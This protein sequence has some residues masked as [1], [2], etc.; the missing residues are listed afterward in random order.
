MS[1]SR[2]RKF[3]DLLDS[4]GGIKAEALG[5]AAST[6]TDIS[7][8]D[9]LST[10]YFD[11]PSGG[12]AQR[13]SSPNI[14]YM[15]YNTN[16]DCI[17]QYT[18]TGWKGID[19][20]PSIVSFTP[21]SISQP[22]ETITVSGSNLKA[23]AIVTFIGDDGTT[24]T[25][26]SVTVIDSET[27]TCIVPASGLPVDSEPFSI[28]VQNP[29]G[30]AATATQ[31]LDAGSKPTWV[32]SGELTN[33]LQIAGSQINAQLSATDPDGDALTYAL[34]AGSSLPT[35]FSVSPN[36]L[37]TGTLPSVASPTTYS[38]NVDVTDGVNTRTN[39]F[40]ILNNK[41]GGGNVAF[42]S[43][44]EAVLYMSSAVSTTVTSGGVLTLGGNAINN[45]EYSAF[46]GD[47]TISSFNAANYFSGTKDTVGSFVLVN[48]NLTINSGI[49]FTPS[50][51]K[52][53][54]VIFVDG[55]LTVNGT[56][57]MSGRGANHSGSG[58]SGGYTAPV[59]LPLIQGSYT[60]GATGGAGGA[61][62][63]SS[64]AGGSGQSNRAAGGGASGYRNNAT[65][66]GG[67]VGTCFSGGAGG[68]GGDNAAGAD[69]GAN[70]GRGGNAGGQ[71][72]GGGDGNPGGSSNSQGVSGKNGTGGTLII[73]CTGTISGSGSVQSRGTDA[74]R[75]SGGYRSGGSA[76]G[77]I[78]QIICNSGSISTDTTAQLAN[79]SSGTGGT[80]GA[81]ASHIITGWSP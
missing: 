30:L 2:A 3:A 69:G 44:E 70:G 6:P 51:R 35:G 23:G 58:D 76:G 68:G 38:F 71:N 32:S 4:N 5:N 24:Y 49:T 16:F 77:G 34:S 67:S 56:I 1:R 57:A 20:P 15:R 37:I 73:F 48:G 55:N 29:T 21:A 74:A 22:G 61:R 28:S 18:S 8:Q 72:A 42:N 36:G 25:S 9:N 11:I 62:G 52:L 81:G 31:L 50:T 10:G 39:A 64:A 78:V 46:N 26:P 19:L 7:D 41:F 79:S 47:Q 65:P 27:L 14:G 40:S 53:Y 12:T 54:T 33:G 63:S 66:G 13:P 80:G 43:F 17:E 60:I 75:K 45:Y 59:S